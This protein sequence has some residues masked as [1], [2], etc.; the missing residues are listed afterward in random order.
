MLNAKQN[1]RAALLIRGGCFWIAG[2]WEGTVREVDYACAKLLT[3]EKSFRDV[4]GSHWVV[5]R[6]YQ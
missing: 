3:E 5:W 2:A 4:P 6:A 1:W